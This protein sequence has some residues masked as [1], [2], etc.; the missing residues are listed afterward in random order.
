MHEAF[1]WYNTEDE[2]GEQDRKPASPESIIRREFVRRLARGVGAISVA[3]ITARVLK[4]ALSEGPLPASGTVETRTV[5]RQEI[6]E[7]SQVFS[8][9]AP[10]MRLSL[11]T[12]AVLKDYWKKKYTEDR[13]FKE[14]LWR[15]Y[16]E[17]GQWDPY[18]REIFKQTGIPEEY[19]FLAIPES[20]WS[21]GEKSKSR[22]RAIGP[23]QFMQATARAYGLLINHAVDERND[24]IKSAGA[25]ARYIKDLHEKTQ[26]W[27][28]ALS[29]YNGGYIW[30][31]LHRCREQNTTPSYEQFLLFLERK[32]NEAR[33]RIRSQPFFVHTVGKGQ[34]LSAIARHYH[35]TVQ[36][37]KLAN[38]LD[39]DLIRENQK[40]N[41]PLRNEEHRR[42]IF[43]QLIAGMKENLNYP[44]KFYAVLELIR[45]SGGQIKRHAP[46]QFQTIEAENVIPGSTPGATGPTL[47]QYAAA[48]QQTIDNLRRLNPA[49]ADIDVPLP[50]NHKI[51]I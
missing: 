14:G 27:N 37:I 43:Y 45:E 6:Q 50:E 40:L 4:R 28:L 2:D 5:Q 32:A 36:E 7:L 9:D 51:R 34:T 25:C 44:P 24:P 17:M 33:E 18:L 47:R 42:K 21:F 39:S 26:D 3:G 49:I 12:V 22:A 48:A 8:Y 19:R 1:P 46:L 35:L 10:E 31:Y 16:A 29:G 15:A 38:G 20:H 30:G 13:G 41:I 23:Y 11:E